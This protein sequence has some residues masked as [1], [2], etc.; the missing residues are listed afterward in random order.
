MASSFHFL[1]E[2]PPKVRHLSTHCL[3]LRVKLARGL[4][5]TLVGAGAGAAFVVM[6]AVDVVPA[7]PI[8]FLKNTA[9]RF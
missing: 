4:G 5:T 9:G 2:I 1:H 7:G 3:P 6:V 8:G